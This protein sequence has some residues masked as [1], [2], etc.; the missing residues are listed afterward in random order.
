M[1]LPLEYRE[2][3]ARFGITR[4]PGQSDAEYMQW[5][6]NIRA[7]IALLREAKSINAGISSGM[8]SVEIR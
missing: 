1:A 8:T 4:S 2:L 3:A 5:L 6:D 7:H